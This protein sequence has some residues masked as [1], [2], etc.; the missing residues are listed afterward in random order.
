[1]LWQEGTGPPL[2]LKGWELRVSVP[3]TEEVQLAQD[4]GRLREGGP[5]P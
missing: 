2:R 1:M 4:T 3:Q 5:E